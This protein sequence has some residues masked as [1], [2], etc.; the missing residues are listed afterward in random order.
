MMNE[1]LV[2]DIRNQLQANRLNI[3]WNKFNS[4]N[5]YI[6]ELT[7]VIIGNDSYMVYPVMSYTTVVG[8]CCKDGFYEIGKY[9]RT[10][11]KQVTQ[12]FNSYYSHMERF[13]TKL[14]TA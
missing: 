13:Y 10:T 12:I 8:F 7:E 2:N 14:R 3:K 5:A 9:S 1:I 6:G 11:S 4:C